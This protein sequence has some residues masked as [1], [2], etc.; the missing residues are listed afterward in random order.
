MTLQLSR[1]SIEKVWLIDDDPAVRAAYVDSVEDLQVTAVNQAGPLPDLDTFAHSLGADAAICD[2]H[3][4]PQNYARFDGA[5]LVS[6][7]YDLK[8]PAILCTKVENAVDEI[9]PHRRGITVRL[10]HAALNPDVTC[11][12]FA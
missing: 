8:F 4:R 7:W 9:R 5:T 3:L 11:A 2:H 12:R 10:H 6:K 1:M